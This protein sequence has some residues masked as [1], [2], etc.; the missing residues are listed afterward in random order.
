ME[1]C[2]YWMIRMREGGTRRK[3]I[4]IGRKGKEN[5]EEKFEKVIRF[6]LDGETRIDQN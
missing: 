2:N 1:K 3:E 6:G 4:C 5:R